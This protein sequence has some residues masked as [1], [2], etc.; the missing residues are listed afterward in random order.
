MNVTITQHCFTL[1][2]KKSSEIRV[3]HFPFGCNRFL[4]YSFF[5]VPKK[6]CFQGFLMG[7]ICAILYKEMVFLWK[8]L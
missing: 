2:S 1:A 6:F 4:S 5:S 7:R 8:K 3:S